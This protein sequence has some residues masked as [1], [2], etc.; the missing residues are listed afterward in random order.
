M[1]SSPEPSKKPKIEVTEPPCAE[2]RVEPTVK[3]K[4]DKKSKNEK[5]TQVGNP[6]REGLAHTPIKTK[7]L[8]PIQEQD[9]A[10]IKAKEEKGSWRNKDH[11]RAEDRRPLWVTRPGSRRDGRTSDSLLT[12]TKPTREEKKEGGKAQARPLPS[13]RP[14]PPPTANSKVT[15]PSSPKPRPT[16]TQRR[17]KATCT[18]RC[19]NREDSEKE[20]KEFV[21]GCRGPSL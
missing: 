7:E 4:I 1:I 19:A 20:E 11:Y 5:K 8:K 9:E 10:I 6:K 18:D 2:P 12:V 21:G 3:P 14:L 17:W 13:P 15:G 16:L